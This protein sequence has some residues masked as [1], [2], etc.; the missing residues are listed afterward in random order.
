M[1]KFTKKKIDGLDIAITEVTSKLCVYGVNT[2]EY[3]EALTILE[4]LEMIR[5]KRKSFKVSPDVI[6]SSTCSLV[7]ILLIL[8]YERTSVITSKAISFIKGRM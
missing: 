5:N 4:K 8:N 2:P 7:G 1:I 3:M 6:I